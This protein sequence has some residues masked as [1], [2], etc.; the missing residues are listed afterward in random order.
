MTTF[1]EAPWP[2]PAIVRPHSPRINIHDATA[3]LGRAHRTYAE[4]QEARENGT[5]PGPITGLP[6]LDDGLGGWLREGIYVLHGGPGVGKTAFALQ[7]AVDCGMP[8]LYVTCEMSPDELFL[9]LTA[10]FGGVSIGVVR[11]GRLAET[12]YW[13]AMDKASLAMHDLE[14]YDGTIATLT[15]RQLGEEL[16]DHFAWTRRLVVIDSL[17]AWAMRVAPDLPEYEAL[18]QAMDSLRSLASEFHI[19][20]LV[21]SE[22]NRSSM[23]AGGLHAAAGSR[24]IEYGCEAMLDFKLEEEKDDDPMA[25]RTE[26]Q[27][28]VRIVKNRYGPPWLKVVMIFNGNSLEFRER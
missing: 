22:R 17:H 8:A 20:I 4:Q 26:S 27:V 11:K 21:I 1:T 28:T 15:A 16:A 23:L 10:R 13:R 3:L 18:N 6:R 25:R 12:D 7:V 19:P 24:R 9:R 2:K 5:A 14:V